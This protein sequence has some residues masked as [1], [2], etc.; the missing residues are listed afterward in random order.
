MLSNMFKFSM[1]SFIALVVFSCSGGSDR[2]KSVNE[3]K[4]AEQIEEPAINGQRIFKVSCAICHG[5]DGKLGANGS[6]DL[7]KSILTLEERIT[8]VTKG[9]NTMPPQEGILS[10]EEIKAVAAYSMTLK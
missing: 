8:M 1:F 2:N 4:P 6:K 7:T 3:G 9:K 10:P 5:N